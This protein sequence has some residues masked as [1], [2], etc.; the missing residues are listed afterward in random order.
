MTLFYHVAPDA[1]TS[2][3]LLCYDEQE[4]RGWRP[5]WKWEG[6]TPF[7]TD[8]VCVYNELSEAQEHMSEYGGQIL[9]I[10][11]PDYADDIRWCKVSE[12]YDAV[13]DR[14]PGQYIRR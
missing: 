4:A 2:G 6:D 3:D 7:D 1:Y 5:E 8:V 11:I 10:D 12:G 14:I 13:Y 9:V